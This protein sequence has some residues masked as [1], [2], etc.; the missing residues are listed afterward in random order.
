MRRS[1]SSAALAGRFVNRMMRG[2]EQGRA[3]WIFEAALKAIHGGIPGEISPG[4]I[5]NG[6]IENT[7]P[8]VVIRRCRVGGMDYHVPTPVPRK[9]GRALAIR[10]IIELARGLSGE[11][12]A[13]RLAKAV[14]AAYMGDL[15]G[16]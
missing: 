13:D 10:G 11:G 1:R 12:M 6:A 3:K 2:G 8:F 14:L 15:G 16:F 7:R 4:Q 9:R 5:L